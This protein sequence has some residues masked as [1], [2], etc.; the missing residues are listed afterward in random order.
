MN[1]HTVD[2]L[3]AEFKSLANDI[4]RPNDDTG[5]WASNKDEILETVK[6]LNPFEA[7]EKLKEWKAYGEEA[8]AELEERYQ[9]WMED[10]ENFIRYNW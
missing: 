10:R 4:L 7:V 8:E 9:D 6:G 3:R 5:L 1:Y 2:T